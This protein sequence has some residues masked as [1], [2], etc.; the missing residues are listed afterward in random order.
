MMSTPALFVRFLPRLALAGLVAALLAVPGCGGGGG[1]DNTPPPPDE[2]PPVN[3]PA[4]SGFGHDAQ[5]TAVSAIAK[6]PAG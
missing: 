6:M 3:G 4:W 2:G 5:H 1:G